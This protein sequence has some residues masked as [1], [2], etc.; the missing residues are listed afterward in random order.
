M[1][2]NLMF[3]KDDFLMSSAPYAYICNGKDQLEREQRRQMV[4]EN[5]MKVG[6]KNFQRLLKGYMESLDSA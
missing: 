2:E 4:S 5:A 6:I 1:N 3:Q